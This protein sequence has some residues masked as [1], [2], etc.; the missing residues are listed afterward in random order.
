MTPDS[1]PEDVYR[2][3][4]RWI[5][6]AF[7]RAAA[8]YEAAAVLQREVRQRLLERLELIRLQP[9]TVLDAGAGTG[10]M[11]VELGRRYAGA[12]IL[13]LDIA[14]A[15]LKL[16]RQKAP[17][18]AR[19][20]G[21]RW[22]VCADAERLPLAE[23]CVDMVVS[24]LML[25]WC[26]DLDAVLAGFQRV[27]RPGGLLMFTTFGPDTLK[28]LRASWSGVDDYSH[29][30]AFIDMHDIGDALLRC[31]F[32]EPVM[33]REDIT[34]TYED[35]TSLMRDLKTLGAHNL[36]GGRPRGLTGR[37]RLARVLEGYEAFRSDGRLPATYEVLYGHCWLPQ[38]AR[39]TVKSGDHAVRVPLSDLSHRRRSS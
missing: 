32:S 13:S 10:E 36:T 22:F 17:R 4:K 16:A 28:E 9:E 3:D 5:R 33:D 30:H 26:D 8:G 21:K 31:G 25:Q 20:R 35:A 37:R 19:W 11:S 2:I 29:V 39:D 1:L 38:T 27:L 15:M 12:R 23:R 7:D 24:N 18:F 14:P 6:A 34:L